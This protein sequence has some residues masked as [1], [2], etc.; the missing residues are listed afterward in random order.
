M[1][2]LQQLFD[3]SLIHVHVNKSLVSV[4][5]AGKRSDNIAAI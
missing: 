2:F 4:V 5:T 1:R 3:T